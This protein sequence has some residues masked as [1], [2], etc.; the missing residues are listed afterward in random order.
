M[1][2]MVVVALMLMTPLIG[3]AEAAA[4]DVYNVT[5]RVMDTYGNPIAM[6]NVEL[7]NG[8]SVQTGQEGYFSILASTG[9]HTLTI[10]SSG[11][12]THTVL[13][14]VGAADLD[15]GTVQM[16]TT[17]VDPLWR[18]YRD[19]HVVLFITCSWAVGSR[20]GA[21]QGKEGQEIMEAARIPG[22]FEAR[23]MNSEGLW[24]LNDGLINSIRT[25][26]WRARHILP[27]EKDSEGWNEE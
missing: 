14:I 4:P 1:V 8:S 20:T 25:S 21:C 26:S 2:M 9:N 24:M 16:Q 6:A 18:D 23:R 7:E 5:G 15:I 3:T 13:I 19:D 27:S 10:S 11:R 17:A 12:D 22:L